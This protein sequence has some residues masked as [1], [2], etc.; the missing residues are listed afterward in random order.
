MA[1]AT[2]AKGTRSRITAAKPAIRKARPL[3]NVSA[4][5]LDDRMREL[6]KRLTT[7]DCK[8]LLLRDRYDAHTAEIALREQELSQTETQTT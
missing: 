4:T 5:D 3:K 2:G 1:K 6:K 8:T 7:A